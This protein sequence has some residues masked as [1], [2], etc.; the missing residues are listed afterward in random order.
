MKRLT[1]IILGVLLCTPL[2]SDMNPYIAGADD[3][4]DAYADILFFWTC[5][6]ATLGDDDYSAGDTTG[7]LNSAAEINATAAK[8]GTNGLY[9]PTGSD[10]YSFDILS[11]DIFASAQGRIGFWW[12]YYITTWEDNAMLFTVNGTE[13]LAILTKNGDELRVTWGASAWTSTSASLVVDT[14]YFVEV[15]YNTDTDSMRVLIDGSEIISSTATAFAPLNTPVALRIGS[16]NG[17]YQYYIDNFMISSDSTRSLYE[18]R[19]LTA[20][21]R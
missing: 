6:S 15:V 16:F 10:Y 4:G 11:N 8:V 21:P 5:E 19:N 14:W 12:K 7:T 20:S 13:D 9:V 17:G 1:L 3:A 2:Y 18:L